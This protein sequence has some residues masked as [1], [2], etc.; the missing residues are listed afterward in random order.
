MG[1]RCSGREEGDLVGDA[2]DER[3]AR[4]GQAGGEPKFAC[5]IIAG[6]KVF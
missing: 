5:R 3:V 4:R 1:H 2:G 6:Q